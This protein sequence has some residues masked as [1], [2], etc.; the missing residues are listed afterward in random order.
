[1][2]IRFPWQDWATGP[3]VDDKL[4]RFKKVLRA[5]LR[6]ERYQALLRQVGLETSEAIGALNSVE[7]VLEQLPP[8]AIDNFRGSLPSF[9]DPEAPQPALQRF[10][11]PLKPTP[12]IAVL[13]P[14][15][16]QAAGIKVFPADLP[17]GL[18]R[19]Q[20]EAMAAPIKLLKSFAG[21]MIAKKSSLP[22]LKNAVIPFSG[23]DHG[24]L[25]EDDR[26]LFWNT[27]QVP[28]FE[29]YLGFDGRVI[30]IECEAHEGLHVITE[31]AIFETRNGSSESELLLTSLTDLC[32]PT[33]RLATGFWGTLEHAQCECGNAEPRLIGLRERTGQP[34]KLAFHCDSSR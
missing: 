3:Q 13:M 16:Q 21:N 32:H 24:E 15:F 34:K 7:Q 17:V 6:T 20:P 19:F 27:F 29:Q 22:P 12:R 26:D 25:T 33:L 2:K 4:T 8:I 5:A 28:I 14:G 11:Y 31:N 18:E 10:R 9:K 1:M 23:I 30:G